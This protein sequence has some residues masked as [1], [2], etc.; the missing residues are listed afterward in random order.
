MAQ[1]AA[2]T[3]VYGTA[4]IDSILLVGNVSPYFAYSSNTGSLQVIGGAGVTGDLYVLGNVISSN[5]ISANYLTA[6]GFA[7]GGTGN[8]TANVVTANSI[9]F[10]DNTSISTS[11]TSVT[12]QIVGGN[13]GTYYFTYY[14]PR[15]FNINS[16]TALVAPL[17]GPVAN[18]A[19]VGIAIGGGGGVVKQVIGS[20]GYFTP[21]N[22]SS[23]Y[24]T[25]TPS[26]NTTVNVGQIIMANVIT[27]NVY[28]SNSIII[29]L[30]MS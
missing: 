8:F 27:S 19:Q 24:A 10:S 9:A 7:L 14:S 22:I 21:N 3:R 15:K 4:S 29:T 11:N 25:Y 17:G 12:I 2:N 23:S 28:T 30:G 5:I 13:P 1:L 26:S 18:V 16:I 6:N 20:P